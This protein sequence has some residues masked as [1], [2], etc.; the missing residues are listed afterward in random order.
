MRLFEFRRHRERTIAIL[1]FVATTA[2]SIGWVLLAY[3]PARDDVTRLEAEMTILQGQ[4]ERALLAREHLPT[5]LAT[6]DD[7]EAARTTFLSELPSQNDVAGLVNQLREAAIRS[8]VTVTSLAQG[9]VAPTGS[10]PDVRTIGFTIDTRGRYAA[11]MAFLAELE[12]LRRY[13]RIDEIRIGRN[14]D[15]ID[16][17]LDARFQVD[18]FVFTG[19]DPDVPIGAP[20]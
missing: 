18:V 8:G 5:V 14:D 15:T 7:L 10:V 13:A 17:S 11:T 2:A 9:A 6:I 1:T 3:Q 16:P 4:L 12:S 20:P 19:P